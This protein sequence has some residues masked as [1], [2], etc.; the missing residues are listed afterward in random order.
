VNST[1]QAK[2]VD[3]SATEVQILET[4]AAQAKTRIQA[5]L[6]AIDDNSDEA[7]KAIA[8]HTFE[9]ERFTW[10]TI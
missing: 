5:N 7:I 9:A 3:Q 10:D 8:D 1:I 2:G 4:F 6:N